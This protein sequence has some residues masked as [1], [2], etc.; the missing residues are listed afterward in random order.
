MPMVPFVHRTV[1]NT[2][3][4]PKG[5][6][7][8]PGSPRRGQE[9]NGSRRNEARDDR[10]CQWIG[11]EFTCEHKHHGESGREPERGDETYREQ[12]A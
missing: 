4:P 6:A 9:H 3:K 12:R 7:S 5:K 8:N 2:I 11:I 10:C 1:V